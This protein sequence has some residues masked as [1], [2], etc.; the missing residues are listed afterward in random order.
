MIK[1]LIK[2]INKSI[3][4]NKKSYSSYLINKKEILI[5]K[6]NEECMELITEIFKKKKKKIINE[7]CDLIYHISIVIVKFNIPLK[8]IRKILLQPN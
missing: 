2:N 1:K 3:K 6:I 8:K 4:K 5:R 7:L